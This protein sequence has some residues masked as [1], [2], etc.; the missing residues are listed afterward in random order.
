MD[1]VGAPRRPRGEP[2]PVSNGHMPLLLATNM[3]HKTRVMVHLAALAG[4]RVHEIA[5]IRGEDVDP[6][7]RTINVTGKGGVKAA[8]PMHQVVLELAGS[9]PRPGW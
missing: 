6:I 4:L 1:K 2:R 3:H 7:G 5:R 8:I 9:M